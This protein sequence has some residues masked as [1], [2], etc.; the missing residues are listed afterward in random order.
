MKDEI[1]LNQAITQSI[2]SFDPNRRKFIFSSEA[3]RRRYGQWNVIKPGIELSTDGKVTF[4]YYAPEAKRIEVVGLGGSMDGRYEMSP[5]GDGWWSVTADDI[6]DGFHYHD[7]Y[8]D[9]VRTIN[10]LVPMGYGCS[11]YYNYFEMPG[12]DNPEAYLLKDVPHGTVR[13]NLYKS[14]LLGGKYRN[15]WVYT[16]P[17]YEKN[18]DRH[19]PVLYIQHGGGENETGWIWQGKLNYIIDNLLAMG[20]CHEMIIVMNNGNA[21]YYTTSDGSIKTADAGEIIVHDCVPFIDGNYRTIVS[22]D[23]RAMAGLSMGGFLSRV[24]V[25]NH[26][27]VFAWCGSFS[28]GFA[29]KWNLFGKEYDYSELFATPESFNSRLK[30]L[31]IGYGEQEPNCEPNRKAC[32]EYID[33]GYHIQFYSHYGYHEWDVWRNCVIHFLPLLFRE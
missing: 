19:Y 32:I 10:P 12:G 6:R 31:Y 7:Y 20:S 24:T 18:I 17:G 29:A 16:P 5:C 26:L 11:N 4:H 27:D 14:T 1:R 15:C 22:R 9:G 33:R 13:M 21:G 8:V 25:F 28:G 23:N 2:M 30:L 3:D